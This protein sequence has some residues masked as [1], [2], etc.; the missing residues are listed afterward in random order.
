MGCQQKV[1]VMTL[2]KRKP[3]HNQIREQ[4]KR[5]RQDPLAKALADYYN[6]QWREELLPRAQVLKQLYGKD[7]Q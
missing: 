4:Y 3:K 2:Q 5:D 6:R 7:T 1:Y